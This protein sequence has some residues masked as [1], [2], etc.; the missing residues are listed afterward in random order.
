LAQR[1]WPVLVVA[2]GIA[3]AAGG[4]ALTAGAGPAVAAPAGV[5]PNCAEPGTVVNMIPWPQQLLGPERVWPFARGDGVT[6]AVLDSGVDANHPQLRGRVLGGF[7]A[8]TGK[9]GA[10]TDCV[11]T[12]TQIAGLI[13]AR[14]VPSIGFVGLAPDVAILPIRVLAERGTAGSITDPG[15]LAR[16]ITAAIERGADVLAIST[17]SYVDSP[18]LRNAVIA[19]Q[20]RGVI[21]VAAVGDLGD[22]TALNPTP[23]PADYDGV[24]GVAAIAESGLRWPKSQHGDY[25][26]LVA[27]GVDVITSQRVRGM[28]L[29]TGTGVATGFVAATA[30]LT[31]DKRGDNVP[32]SEI[33]RILLATAVPAAGGPG[34]GN[35]VVNPYAAVNDQMVKGSPATLPALE[36]PA[37]EATSAWAA[38]REL[39]ITGTLIALLAV[40][41][42]VAVA[43]AVPR[44]RRRLWRSA[45]APAPPRVVE[46]DEPG[47]PVQLFDEQ[48][49]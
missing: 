5:A 9:G 20:A 1:R 30:A 39:A 45:M 33:R 49:Q 6:V 14:Q 23:Y 17:I 26:D 13:A 4:F 31:R 8:I 28:T 35:G 47:P 21:V 3:M 48:R 38:S 44:G 11:G 19:A 46:P 7:D 34:Y 18:A 29:A 40:I 32:A 27:P 22:T 42:V 43:V 36:R 12:G 15:I 37:A 24:I 16:G 25:V 10:N 2:W 41:V